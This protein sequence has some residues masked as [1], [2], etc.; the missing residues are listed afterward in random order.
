MT[1]KEEQAIDEIINRVLEW[2]DEAHRQVTTTED[3]DADVIASHDSAGR[4]IELEIKPGLP[5]ELNTEELE[6]K[7]N[8]ALADN[9][10]RG[11]KRLDA[12]ADKYLDISDIGARFPNNAADGHSLVDAFRASLNG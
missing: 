2:Q 8:E 5:R 11:K 12:L 6:T 7:I 4:L 1:S 10:N 3:D 9:I